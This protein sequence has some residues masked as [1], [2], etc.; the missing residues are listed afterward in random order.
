MKYGVVAMDDSIIDQ[1]FFY[2]YSEQVI[3]VIDK[4]NVHLLII[5]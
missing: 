2:E 5:T 4:K 3:V 1:M